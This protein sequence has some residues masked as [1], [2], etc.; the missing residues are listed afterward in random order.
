MKK[1]DF[2]VILIA[3][4]IA[5]VFSAFTL[6]GKKGDTVEVVVD[7]EMVTSFTLGANVEYEINTEFG[8]NILVIKD[9]KA[10]I[11]DAD[12][13]DKICVKHAAISKKGESIICL[14]HRLIV[15]ISGQSE[16]TDGIL[17]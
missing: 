15:R 7:G 2:L 3:L 13:R 1:M 4:V 17:N 9:G 12:C 16:D 8:K 14:P 5:G 6:T 11:I 10:E